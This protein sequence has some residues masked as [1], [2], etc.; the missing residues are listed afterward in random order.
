MVKYLE[1]LDIQVYICLDTNAAEGLEKK[2]LD[3]ANTIDIASLKEHM[4]ITEKQR[5]IIEQNRPFKRFWMIKELDGIG[6][7]FYSKFFTYCKNAVNKPASGK[8]LSMFDV[9]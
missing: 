9:L 8:Q 1:P 6:I 3:V 4:R 7:T 5:A 2:M